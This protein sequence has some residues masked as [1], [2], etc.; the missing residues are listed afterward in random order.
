MLACIIECILCSNKHIQYNTTGADIHPVLMLTENSGIER[1]KL[2]LY[3]FVEKCNSDFANLSIHIIFIF[4]CGCCKFYESSIWKY[5]KSLEL[6]FFSSLHI[7]CRF[8]YVHILIAMALTCFIK[9]AHLYHNSSFL[10][11]WFIQLSA[12][13]VHTCIWIYVDDIMIL[14]Y[15]YS[16]SECTKH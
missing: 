11:L 2:W 12:K 10:A 15:S 1:V 8:M 5:I 13:F 3:L 14:F 9:H 16:F 6:M 4:S 7:A